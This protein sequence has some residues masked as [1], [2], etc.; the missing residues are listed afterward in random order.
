MKKIGGLQAAGFGLGCG[1]SNSSDGN[2][3]NTVR[4]I[5][6]I[7]DLSLV[8]LGEGDGARRF[9]TNFKN[10]GRSVFGEGNGRSVFRIIGASES[11]PKIAP[12]CGVAEEAKK[13]NSS[14]FPHAI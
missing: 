11:G 3:G 12:F 8:S 7:S 6:R 2:L 1:N 5:K 4:R 10:L 13:L 14:S 9:E